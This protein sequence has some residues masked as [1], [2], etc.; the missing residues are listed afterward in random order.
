[1]LNIFGKEVDM[2]GKSFPQTACL[3]SKVNKYT[4]ELSFGRRV[5]LYREELIN[6]NRNLHR[7]VYKK[8]R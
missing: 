8:E 4:A 1:M 5:T 6:V 2:G 3:S 7:A